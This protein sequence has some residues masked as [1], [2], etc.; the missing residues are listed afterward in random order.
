MV[1]LDGILWAESALVVE[2]GM[3][4]AVTGINQYIFKYA[5]QLA[6][7]LN[8]NTLLYALIC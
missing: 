6:V 7:F 1:A 3:T 5:S 4:I 2:G 8:V